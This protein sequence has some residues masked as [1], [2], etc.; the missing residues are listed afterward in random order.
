M[1]YVVGDV[2]W[3]RATTDAPDDPV[4]Y[5]NPRQLGSV[6][7]VEE[8]YMYCVEVNPDGAE[9]DGLRELDESQIEGLASDQ[10]Q[11]EWLATYKRSPLATTYLDRAGPYIGY[12]PE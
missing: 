3:L 8:K 12:V 10:E 2:V 5:N 9:D 7:I 1:P 11:A 4:G 6:L